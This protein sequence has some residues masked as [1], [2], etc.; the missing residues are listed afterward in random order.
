MASYADHE[1]IYRINQDLMRAIDEITVSSYTSLAG[2]VEKG[3]PSRGLNILQMILHNVYAS[4]VA[5]SKILRGERA[6]AA[7]A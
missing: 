4:H 1:T 7:M 3:R 6:F 5:C 2:R